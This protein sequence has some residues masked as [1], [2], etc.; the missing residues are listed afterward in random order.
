MPRINVLNNYQIIEFMASNISPVNPRNQKHSCF[1]YSNMPGNNLYFI[2]MYETKVWRINDSISYYN[3][4]CKFYHKVW[5]LNSKC[6]IL[7]TE[8]FSR[9][10]SRN[11]DAKVLFW[12]NVQSWDLLNFSQASRKIPWLLYGND[13]IM[14]ILISG[15]IYNNCCSSFSYFLVE[16]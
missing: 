7:N 13:I 5:Y 1:Y 6:Y 8:R 4:Y 11:F 14:S 9:K 2:W 16:A 15:S 10:Q 12:G 3:L